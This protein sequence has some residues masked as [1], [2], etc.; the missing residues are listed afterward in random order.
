MVYDN[1]GAEVCVSLEMCVEGR[2][3]SLKGICSHGWCTHGRRCGCE[4]TGA[5]GVHAAHTAV[6]K[7]Q[8]MGP[9]VSLPLP[10]YSRPTKRRTELFKSAILKS[11]IDSKK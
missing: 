4:D 9:M 5:L 7:I 3:G 2:D 8:P 10:H 6:E 11:N 1:T